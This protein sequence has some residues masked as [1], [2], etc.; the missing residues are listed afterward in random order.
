MDQKRENLKGILFDWDLTL[1][2]ALGDVPRSQRLTVLFQRSGFICSHEAVQEAMAVLHHGQLQGQ[3]NDIPQTPQTQEEIAR[4]YRRL[5]ELLGFPPVNQDAALALY[6]DYAHLP[7]SLYNDVLPT[8]QKLNTM[9]FAL[10]IISNHSQ[11]ARKVMQSH[12]GEFVPGHQIIISDEIG[13]YKPLATIFQQAAS[14]MALRPEQCAFVGDNL[15][16][17]A[18]GAIEQGGFALA[19]WLDRANSPASPALPKA[20]IRITSLAEIV[21]YLDQPCGLS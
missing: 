3:F 18:I 15:D 14:R 8:L 5:L 1:A 4:Y 21:A 7:T 9:G 10:G 2:R 19:F 11:A 6:D 13:A 16:V 12:L 20:V 17:D